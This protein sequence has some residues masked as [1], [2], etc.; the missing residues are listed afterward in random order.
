MLRSTDRLDLPLLIEN[1]LIE[2]AAEYI[3]LQKDQM[4]HGLNAQ[5]KTI[6][7]YRNPAYARRKAAINPLAGEGNVDLKDK[8]DFYREIFTDVRADEIIVDSSDTKSAALQK[9]YGEDIFGLDNDSKNEYVK[10]VR[11]VFLEM[12]TDQLNK[13]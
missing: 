5:G 3:G 11:P 13:K 4:L 8:G 2:T 9:K 6:G 1:S 10:E 12:V 7:K